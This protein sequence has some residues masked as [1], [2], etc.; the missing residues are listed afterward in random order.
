MHVRPAVCLATVYFTREYGSGY[1]NCGI[2]EVG[3]TTW[4]DYAGIRGQ[5][6]VDV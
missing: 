3:A 5:T 2:C 1:R 6:V 4:A